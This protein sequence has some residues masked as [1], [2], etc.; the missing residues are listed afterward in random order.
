MGLSINEIE[1]IITK[2]RIAE[3]TFYIKNSIHDLI[4]KLKLPLP[5]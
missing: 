1:R 5:F 4:I 2:I 3:T